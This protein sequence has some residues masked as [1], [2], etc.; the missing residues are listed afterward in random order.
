MFL[1]GIKFVYRSI[2]FVIAGFIVFQATKEVWKKPLGAQYLQAQESEAPSTWLTGHHR[3]DPNKL[4]DLFQKLDS[5]HDGYITFDE[6]DD[7][8]VSFD[9]LDENGDGKI[10]R[11]EFLGIEGQTR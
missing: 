5:N 10:S 6:W 7:S 11:G 9:Q 1:K 2:L 4:L 3:D 8:R